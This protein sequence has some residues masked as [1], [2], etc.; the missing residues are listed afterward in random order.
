MQQGGPPS[1][2]VGSSSTPKSMALPPGSQRTRVFML[3]PAFS[4]SD[5]LRDIAYLRAPMRRE[6]KENALEMLCKYDTVI[7]VDDSASMQRDRRWEQVRLSMPCFARGVSSGFRK[8]IQGTQR[9]CSDGC[10]V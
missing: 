10:H 4:S 3:H 7:I 2:A 6:S 1:A 8:G 5:R 9:A